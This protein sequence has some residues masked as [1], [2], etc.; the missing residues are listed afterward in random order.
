MCSPANRSIYGE[1]QPERLT[2]SSALAEAGDALKESV[3]T[4]L[5]NSV[6]INEEVMTSHSLWSLRYQTLPRHR[7]L[8]ASQV[9]PEW[10]ERVAEAFF[11]VFLYNII[12]YTQTNNS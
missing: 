12:I 2:E 11:K 10:Q 3:M 1:G 7:P 6:L 9:A 5:S 8:L 4:H